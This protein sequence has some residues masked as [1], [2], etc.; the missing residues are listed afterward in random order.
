MLVSVLEGL[1]ESQSL[2]H[3]SSY[4]KIVHGDLPQGAFVIDDE[5]SPEMDTSGQVRLKQDVQC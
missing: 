1:D 3:R 2:I 5:K 4:W